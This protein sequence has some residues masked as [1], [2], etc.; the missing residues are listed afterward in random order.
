ML[1]RRFVLVARGSRLGEE[2]T[3]SKGKISVH[4]ETYPLSFTVY[5]SGT[6]LLRRLSSEFDV[7]Y[8]GA[9]HSF[10]PVVIERREDRLLLRH[11]DF[12][13]S[14]R[15]KLDENLIEVSWSSRK[16]FE[17]VTD[18]W[19]AA[20]GGEWYGQGQL[21]FQVFPLS[22]HFTVMKPFLA[23]NIQV[24]FWVNRSGG[25]ILVDTYEL[26]ESYFNG[27]IV[28]R[29]VYSK[30]FT[31][32]IVVGEN[33]RDARRR[34]LERVGLAGRRPDSRI[35]A[36]PIFST[37]AYFKKNIDEEKV[38][39][40]AREIRD[41]EFPC[42][43]VE[44]DDK[45]EKNYGDFTFD[46]ERFPDPKELVDEIHGMGYLVTLWVY[47][48]INYE[49]ENFE[50]AKDRGYLVLDP[51]RD[52]PARVRWWNGEGGLLDI[53][54]PEAR[55]WFSGLLNKL[56]RDYGINGFKFDAGDG[57]F[58]PLVKLKRGVRLGRTYGNLMPNQ[59]TDEW[60]RF[61]AEYHYDLAEA[62]VG[63]LAQRYGV[64]AR[65][66]DKESTWGLDNGLYAAVT[67]A[68]TLSLT[69]YHYVMPDMIGGNEYRFKCDKEL[70][71][72]WVEATA[73]MPVVQY[74]IPPWR[75]DDETVEISRRYSLLHLALADYYV[76]LAEK[77]MREGEPILCPLVLRYPDDDE[78]AQISDEYLIG[79]LLVAP[80]LDRG[81]EEREVYLPKGTWISFWNGREVKGPTRIVVEA[82]LGS[83]PLFAE[84]RD[85]KLIGMLK[86]ARKRIFG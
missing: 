43:V 37:W 51:E 9:F 28:V 39:E 49:S 8:E 10:N 36:K 25:G 66:G 13:L 30:S 64:V 32:H 73:L 70:F 75:F 18:V 52:E 86:E 42:S 1:I 71:I 46:P 48:F 56:K 72:R 84:A 23:R 80:I 79:N 15:L 6:P 41:H 55:S 76:E 77:A 21:R 4:V 67:Q 47:P 54:N 14:L 57:H 74:S 24:P 19:I 58:F 11:R 27:G 53:S 50:Y 61:I 65:E 16:N 35:L 68:L 44:I 2:L 81:R 40:Y 31:Y 5:R 3:L 7:E 26:F 38:L 83:L 63:F 69:G 62:R 22:G 82:P 34:F 29:G 33:L 45:W 85:T 59:Y 20:R 17:S 12:D 60:L 78:C